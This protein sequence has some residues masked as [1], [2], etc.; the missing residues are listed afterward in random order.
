MT[1]LEEAKI[2]AEA[3]ALDLIHQ[4]LDHWENMRGLTCK[5]LARRTG[6]GVGYVRAILVKSTCVIKQRPRNRMLWFTDWS[7]PDLAQ[8]RPIKRPYRRW[9]G[10]RIKADEQKPKS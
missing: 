6:L 8:Y 7:D 5:E 10:H 1:L 2:A 3:R 9:I 4:Q